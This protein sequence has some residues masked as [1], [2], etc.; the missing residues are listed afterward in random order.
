[1][2][3]ELLSIDEDL[4]SIPK[5]LELPTPIIPVLT[6]QARP[7]AAYLGQRG[8]IARPIIW[9]TVPKGA[10]RLRVCLHGGNT[11]HEVDRLVGALVEWARTEMVRR[12]EAGMDLGLI[13]AKL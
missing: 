12:R 13:Q 3:E 5:E 10:D 1:M 6:S 11:L 9:P 4:L 2:R 7:L 8:I